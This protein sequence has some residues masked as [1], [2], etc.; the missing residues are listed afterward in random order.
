MR[1]VPRATAAGV[2]GPATRGVLVLLAEG[3]EE[4]EA[5]TVVDVLRR[6]QL[7]VTVASLAPRSAPGVGGCL[8]MGAHGIA[9]AADAALD[10]LDTQRF[11]ALVLPGGMPGTKHLA[12]DARVIAIVQRFAAAGRPLAA[13]CAAPMVLARA[14]VLEGRQATSHPS[15]RAKL[16]GA[17]VLG[18]PAVVTSDTIVTSQGVGTALAFALELVRQWKGREVA[19]RLAQAMIA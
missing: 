10:D 2:E 18:E 8:V 12:D 13:I 17:T 15:V 7:E 9:V 6:A 14:G 19:E 16:G 3:F 1:A 11:G 4:I 5:V